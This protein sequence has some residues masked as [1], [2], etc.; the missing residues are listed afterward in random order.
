MKVALI[1]DRLN[2]VG[3]AEQILV[4]LA[5]IYP[6]ATWY[7]SF[8]DK[9]GAPFSRD[10]D[11]RASIF[12]K[13]GF[14]RRHHEL[15]PFL[16]PFIFESIDLSN[17]DLVISVGSAES[18]SV[19][20]SPKT[21]HINYCLTPTRYLWSHKLEYLATLPSILKPLS[22]LTMSLMG[23]WDYATSRRPDILISISELVK[24]RVNKYYKLNTEV[25]YPP[26]DTNEVSSV[27]H[28]G[29]Y[30][31][32]V[33]RLVPYKNID[34]IVKAF[35]KNG[36]PLVIVGTGLE[37]NKLKKL[38]KSNIAFTGFLPRKN[39]V[40]KYLS[41]KAY[42]QANIEDFGISMVEALSAGKPVIAYNGGGAREIVDKE[43]GVLYNELSVDSLTDAVNKFEHSYFSRKNC[44]VQA[45]KFDKK[46]WKKIIKRRINKAWQT[47]KKN[48]G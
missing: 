8:W 33:S 48:L 6:E 10:W 27:G 32:V 39:V 45:K 13:I 7:T 12:N 29:N 38:A 30:Y 31:L 34:L 41:C 17:Y 18:K 20:T 21:L 5:R 24:K 22:S 40:E 9:D 16:M 1:Y 3:G 15:V 4:E 35:N 25:I 36:K 14:L 19:I 46:V 43:C 2:K 47:H 44:L 28:D 23:K 37:E 11:V 26:V 42:V